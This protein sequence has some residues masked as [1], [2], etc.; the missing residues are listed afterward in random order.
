M[1]ANLR[2]SFRPDTRSKMFATNAAAQPADEPNVEVST[3]D[4]VASA[5]D[6]CSDSSVSN[7]NTELNSDQIFDGTS[8]QDDAVSSCSESYCGSDIDSDVDEVCNICQAI[9]CGIIH[10]II[11]CDVCRSLLQNKTSRRALCLQMTHVVTRRGPT[12]FPN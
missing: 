5:E 11:I 2:A 10:S 3:T 6:A 8:D 1:K 9:C 7:E 12:I 4:R